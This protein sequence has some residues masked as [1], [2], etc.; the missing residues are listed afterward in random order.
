MEGQ[1]LLKTKNTEIN[2]SDWK[3]YLS[4]LIKN[5][6]YLDTSFVNGLRRYAIGKINCTTFEYS[7]SPM[8]RDYIIF[9][10]NT[11]NMNNDFIGHRIGLVP[12]NI[13]GVKYILL[14]YKILIGHHS[15]LDNILKDISDKKEQ[16]IK[17]LKTN[18]KL[19]KNIDIIS[20]INFYINEKNE[21]EDI[22]NITTENILFKFINLDDNSE[23]ELQKDA[24]KR[25]IPLFKLYEEYN[26]ISESIAEDISYNNLM[27]LV[28]NY[29]FSAEENNK[30]ILLCKL[31]Q[32]ETLKCKM[33]LNIGNGEKHARWSPVCPCTYSFELDNDLILQILNKKCNESKLTED[34]LQEDINPENYMLIKEFI[35]SRYNEPSNFV[36]TPEKIKEK[37]D[38]MSTLSQTTDYNTIKQYIS[39]KDTLLNTFN[40]CDYQRY[41]KGK[42][43]FELFNREFNLK[44]EPVGFYSSE[45][46]LYKIFK[47]LKN[48]LIE[49][50]NNI[51]ELLSNYS[52]FPMKNAKTVIS[53]SDKIENGIDI[54]F[55]NSNHSIG[56]ILSSYIYHL[57]L[58]NISYIAYKMVH[59]LKKEMLIT[60]GLN[61]ITDKSNEIKN[62]FEN[63]NDIFKKMELSTFKSN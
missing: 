11:S 39:N 32:N 28:F 20:K 10:K 40:K 53:D 52:N 19:E 62:I 8:I 46:I 23:F 57:N 13:I 21:G 51:L 59:P 33:N 25:F 7:P 37:Q 42:E 4:N 30:G 34:N 54:L 16:S 15:E 60:I 29:I 6:H 41:Y 31:K 50:C 22:K 2:P 48:N 27:N 38:F 9:E 3:T 49:E 63:L 58:E 56:N 35:N 24:I 44:I 26:N 43:E 18:L 5:G 55:T 61:N 36:L 1:F 17:N 45:R 12:V 47:L 14:I